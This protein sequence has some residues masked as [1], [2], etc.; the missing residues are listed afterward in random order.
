MPLMLPTILKNLFTGYAT[1]LY[2]VQIR[3]PFDKARGQIRF[4]EDKCIMCGL[5]AR[6][7]PSVA[8]TT[9]KKKNELI[10]YPLRC[11]VCEVCVHACP[12]DAIELLFKWRAPFYNKPEELYKSTRLELLRESSDEAKKEGSEKSD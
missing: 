4:I 5:C 6:V 1:R 3:E 12:S 9:D 11:I 7:C 10:F 2:P 8:I